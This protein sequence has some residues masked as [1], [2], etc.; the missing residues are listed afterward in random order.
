[1]YLHHNYLLP[2]IPNTEGKICMEIQYSLNNNGLHIFAFSYVDH[3]TSTT[4][5]A[6]E[7]TYHDSGRLMLPILLQ[8]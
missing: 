8:N 2:E 4:Q 7:N 1:M 6:D 3:Q 5:T